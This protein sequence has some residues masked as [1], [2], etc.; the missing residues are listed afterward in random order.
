MTLLL[1]WKG[2]N[3]SMY[4]RIIDENS[5]NRPFAELNHPTH[6]EVRNPLIAVLWVI[7]QVSKRGGELS[8]V[9]PRQA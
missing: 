7:E 5:E 3:G 1:Y 8:A 9:A 6:V 2:K 4:H